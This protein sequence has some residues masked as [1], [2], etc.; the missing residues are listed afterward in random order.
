[1]SSEAAVAALGTRRR[2]RIRVG[3]FLKYVALFVA[4]VSIALLANGLFEVWFSYQ[5]HKAALVRI[6]REQADSASAKISQFFKEIEGQL[7]W[8]T[9]LPWAATTL[10]Q[11]RFDALRLLKQVP[12]VSELSQLDASGKEQLRVSRFSMDVMASGTDYANDPKRTEAVA[13]KV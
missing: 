2:S 1:M 7:G 8:T 13:R 5:E 6:Q 10:E 4:V 11:R 12:A 3:L 9:Q